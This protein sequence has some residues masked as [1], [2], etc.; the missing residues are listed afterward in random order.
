[1]DKSVQNFS[2]Y[3][4]C[5]VTL[6]AEISNGRIVK[7]D[8]VNKVKRHHSKQVVGNISLHLSPNQP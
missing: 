6:L 5:V 7:Y 2:P 4:K 1:M 3:L 8:K